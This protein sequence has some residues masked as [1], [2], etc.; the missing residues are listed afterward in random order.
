[1]SVETS[2]NKWLFGATAVAIVL[3]T[4]SF[5]V[6][7]DPRFKTV[8]VLMAL[9]GS[10]ELIRNFLLQRTRKDYKFVSSKLQ[11]NLDHGHRQLSGRYRLART[12][13]SLVDLEDLLRQAAPLALAAVEADAVVVHLN[14]NVSLTIP[15]GSIEWAGAGSAFSTDLEEFCS[16]TSPFVASHSVDW[17]GENE[18]KRV[19]LLRVPLRAGDEFFGALGIIRF[20]AGFDAGGREYCESIGLEIAAG[21]SRVVLYEFAVRSAEHDY[22][23]GLLNHRAISQ[24]FRTHFQNDGEATAL[25]LILLDISNF[26]TLND[27]HGHAVGDDILRIV[28][29]LLQES[30]GPK[31]SVGRTGGDEFTILL[32]RADVSACYKVAHDILNMVCSMEFAVP[33]YHETLPVSVNIGVAA[34][35]E[36][37]TNP[38]QLM[39]KA[40][41]NLA[42]AK[43]SRVSILEQEVFEGRKSESANQSLSTIELMLTAID[44][45]DSY[46]RRHSQDVSQFAT[47]ISQELGDSQ[48]VTDIIALSA[49]MHDL[50]KIAV[51]ATILCRPGALSDAEFDVLKLHPTIGATIAKTLPE[52]EAVMDG[53]MYHHERFDGRGYPEGLAGDDIPYLGRVIAAADALSAMTT[54]RPYRKGM[55]FEVAADRIRDGIGT[56]FCPVCG[57]ALLR[58]LIKRDIISEEDLR[59]A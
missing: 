36:S 13:N 17:T 43:Q 37:S 15:E 45:V 56:Q 32:P 12:L 29:R 57:P 53:I 39:A 11:H 54:D 35:P 5:F 16:D 25:G 47:W 22:L 6:I 41:Q 34:Y 49:L 51:P 42:R 33:N 8:A 21:L 30:V 38:F 19:Q 31:G 52:M 46:T 28:A 27:T 18:T 9:A 50:G 24:L 59:A 10:A 2:G 20:G 26:K 1:M 48:E 40:D 23:T 58:A 3:A 4:G 14:P 7:Q 44:R 55:S